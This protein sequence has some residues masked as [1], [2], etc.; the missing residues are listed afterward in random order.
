MSTTRAGVNESTYWSHSGADRS[1]LVASRTD[2]SAAI[3]LGLVVL[4]L[5][6]GAELAQ[7]L[8]RVAAR[9]A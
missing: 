4:L 7:H 9:E 1:R 5:F 3:V 6:C 8:G 2:T